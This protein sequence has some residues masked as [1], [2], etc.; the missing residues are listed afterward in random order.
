MK[1]TINELANGKGVSQPVRE[2][3]LQMEA[4]LDATNKQVEI[5][6]DALAESRR[7]VASIM[8]AITDPENQPSQF[9]TVT[10][11]YMQHEVATRG[12]VM[13]WP[14]PPPGGPVP[15]TPQQ[16]SEYQRQQRNQLPESPF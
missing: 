12:T 3:L 13:T 10:L 5:L 4:E 14:F 9:G 16:E 1:Y 6:S 7:E 8:Q 11:A 2:A 15:W